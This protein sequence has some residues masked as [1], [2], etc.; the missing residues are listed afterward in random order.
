MCLVIGVYL[1]RIQRPLERHLAA[2]L[3]AAC[4]RIVSSGVGKQ[5]RSLPSTSAALLVCAVV[6]KALG[7]G[8]SARHAHASVLP[9][10]PIRIDHQNTATY[11]N[12][13]V[14]TRTTLQK[15][16]LTFRSTSESDKTLDILEV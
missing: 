3:L 8:D 7:R 15:G 11:G 10:R 9:G 4:C 13:V 1:H 12:V 6:M 14:T 5:G 2:R 16:K